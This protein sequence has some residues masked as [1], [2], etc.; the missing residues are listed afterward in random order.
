MGFRWPSTAVG[1]RRLLSSPSGPPPIHRPQR[2]AP[3][4]AV[5]RSPRARA[6]KRACVRACARACVRAC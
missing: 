1:P 6:K 3:S 4:V 5:R 2:V